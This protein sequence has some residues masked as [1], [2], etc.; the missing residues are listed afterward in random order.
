MP[1]QVEFLGRQE[2]LPGQQWLVYRNVRTGQITKVPEEVMTHATN[3]PAMMSHMQGQGFGSSPADPA[4]EDTTNVNR[5][6][7]LQHWARAADAAEISARVPNEVGSVPRNQFQDPLSE[8]MAQEHVGLKESG[9]LDE[10]VKRERTAKTKYTSP[11]DVIEEIRRKVKG[12][13]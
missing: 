7:M 12:G 4:Q 9:Q 8:A 3:G 2:L 6:N 11:R 5:A 13:V 1:D 10:I